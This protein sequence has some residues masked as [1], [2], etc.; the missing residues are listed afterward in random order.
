M[1]LKLLLLVIFALPTTT[2]LSQITCNGRSNNRP[3]RMS[4]DMIPLLENIQCSSLQYVEQGND[5]IISGIMCQT[6]HSISLYFS[7]DNSWHCTRFQSPT[8]WRCQGTGKYNVNTYLQF[9]C[10]RYYEPQ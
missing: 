4:S 3:Y 7:Q 8:S 6:E 5:R 10:R 1:M 9:T 2:S